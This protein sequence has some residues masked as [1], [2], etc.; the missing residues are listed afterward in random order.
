MIALK[1]QVDRKEE[2]KDAV[3]LQLSSIED[4]S[5][6]SITIVKVED[7]AALYSVRAGAMLVISIEEG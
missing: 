3:I 6:M 1:T 7:R 2:T 5:N 4:N